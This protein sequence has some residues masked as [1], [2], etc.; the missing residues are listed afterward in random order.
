MKFNEICGWFNQHNIF[1]GFH[2]YYYVKIG[3]KYYILERRIWVEEVCGFGFYHTWQNRDFFTNIYQYND[4]GEL[5]EELQRMQGTDSPRSY[6]EL[7]PFKMQFGRAIDLSLAN[8]SISKTAQT[9]VPEVRQLLREVKLAELKQERKKQFNEGLSV[10]EGGEEFFKEIFESFLLGKYNLEELKKF[11]K[12]LPSLL[13]GEKFL[14]FGHT[15]C[16][17]KFW[18]NGEV[19]PPSPIEVAEY[20]TN[21]RYKAL[22]P[23]WE[24]ENYLPQKTT[25][26]KR[27]GEDPGRDRLYIL[28]VSLINQW[29]M[30]P[31]GGRVKKHKGVLI[32]TKNK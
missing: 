10:P 18:G 15:D 22:R 2:A 7:V 1:S 28:P 31:N 3:E 8:I 11:L 26:H 19:T 5:D 12:E 25:I 24:K 32:A 30:V 29:G 27:M 16:D 14:A 23:F 21:P 17:G 13:K 6:D 4:I 9:D 20:S